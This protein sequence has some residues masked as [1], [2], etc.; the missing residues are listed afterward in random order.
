MNK[1]EQNFIKV[2]LAAVTGQALSVDVDFEQTAKLA[3]FHGVQGLLFEAIKNNKDVPKAIFDSL[4]QE[5][6]LLLVK[7]ANQEN[8]VS[9]LMRVFEQREI[10][11]VMLKGWHMKKFYP[12]PDM[13]L[14][15]DTDMF[16]KKKDEQIIHSILKKEGY[17][18][19][20]F[21]E[22]KDNVYNKKPFIILEMHKN[23]FMFEDGW[24]TFFN[25][26]GSQMYIWN[27]VEKVEG[28]EYI[29]RMDD[30][31]FFTYMIAH[32]AKHLLD[33]GGIGVKAFLDVWLF[34]EKTPDLKLDIALR[35]LS[36]LGLK[37]FTQK[38]IDLTQLW[39][40]GKNNFD[41]TVEEFGEYILE[42]GVYG[43]SKFFVA[44]KD[45][46]MNSRKPSQIK[47]VFRRAFPT[48]EAMK[49][50]YP[51]LRNNIL[52]LPF[53]YIKR[54]AYSLINRTDSVKGEIEKSGEIDYNEVKKIHR[55][56]QKIG[57][58]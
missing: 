4:S 47:Y 16:I 29:Y 17:S 36:V 20:S 10:P 57:L 12:R 22:K 7:D 3:H 40:S 26:K 15:A 30:E 11:V 34:L 24:N 44:T 13:R 53:L 21:G 25:S 9:K 19:V 33:D 48:V 35:D 2:I 49:T 5:Q 14:M 38:V 1:Y 58:R 55:L 42:C 51:Q 8:E 41:K 37:E 46:L 45:G 52:L 39:F 54:L 27:R 23:L 43:N 50:R 6:M 31:L 18:V 32:I 56:Y 28:F